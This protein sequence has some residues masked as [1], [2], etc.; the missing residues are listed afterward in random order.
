MHLLETPYRCL[1]AAAT[2]L[3]PPHFGLLPLRPG[4][5]PDSPRDA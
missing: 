5:G 4:C 1:F 3:V 2:V